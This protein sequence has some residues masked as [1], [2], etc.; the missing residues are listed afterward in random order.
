MPHDASKVLMGNVYSSDRVISREDA[1]PASFP[2]GRA[3]RA[4]SDGSI[5]LAASD[6]PIKG[7]SLGPSLSDTQKTAVC[8]V[9]N[10]VPISIAEYL[11]KAQL[12]FISKRPGIVINIELVA[13]AT[14]GSEV[15]TVTGSD[16][17]G[18][19]I[20]V[21]MDNVTTKSTTTQIKAALDGSAPAAALIDTVIASG[22]GSTEV[23]AFAS[24]TIDSQAQAVIGAA[25]RVSDTTG[26]AILA[27]GTLTGGVY[28]SGAKTA[29]DP[30]TGLSMG[31]CALVDM[32]GGL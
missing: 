2:A 7:V 29:I 6:G 4:K 9:G 19:L 16:A 20:S 32:G 3:V 12:T 25:V 5:S 18:Y 24:D 1:N 15:V 28:V 23:D 22:Q 27:G 17:A 8:R 10:L 13:G 14:A 30:H 26:I 31:M 11:V 21:S